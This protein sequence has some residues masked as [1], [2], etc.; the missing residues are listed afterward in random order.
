VGLANVC[1]TVMVMVLARIYMHG[2]SGRVL[3]ACLMPWL[4]F[5]I[6]GVMCGLKRVGSSQ[7]L[8]RQ[9]LHL[10]DRYACSASALEGLFVKCLRSKVICICQCS[11]L[12]YSLSVH[13]SGCHF[14]EEFM[15][16]VSA[17]WSLVPLGQR[18]PYP[19]TDRGY[20]PRLCNGG[21]QLG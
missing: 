5:A 4:W 8:E 21:V 15:G 2:P 3:A 10:F 12:C 16:A 17:A 11:C 6:V 7:L 9:M 14:Q 13:F 1:I 20:I 19:L 18:P